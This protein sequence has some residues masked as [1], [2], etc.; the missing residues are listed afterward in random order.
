M[1]AFDG[2]VVV[3]ICSRISKS[4]IHAMTHSFNNLTNVK[5]NLMW[6]N[7]SMCKQFYIGR[8]IWTTLLF[9]HA[10]L[11]YDILQGCSAGERVS[12]NVYLY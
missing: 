8:Y 3:I 9:V 12:F 6:W 5:R 1:L 10:I 7:I 11:G 2:I 4:Q